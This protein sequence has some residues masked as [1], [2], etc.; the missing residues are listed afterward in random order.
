MDVLSSIYIHYT[1][2]KYVQA[3]CVRKYKLH[4]GYVSSSDVHIKSVRFIYYLRIFTDNCLSVISVFIYFISI[5]T[6]E[7][8][9]MNQ[10]NKI[11]SERFLVLI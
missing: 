7:W 5:V 10:L 6:I 3:L 4:T 8:I 1:A 11:K 9:Y 2:S